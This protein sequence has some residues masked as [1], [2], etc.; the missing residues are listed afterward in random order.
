MFVLQFVFLPYINHDLHLFASAWNHHPIRTERNWS[1]KKIWLNGVLNPDDSSQTTIQDI[2]EAI[3]PEGL[4][5]F[6][7]DF[8][9]ADMADSAEVPETLSPLDEEQ[10]KIN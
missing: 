4:E 2:I 6:G 3:P 8:N 9:A 7:V 1:P 10:M 5:M